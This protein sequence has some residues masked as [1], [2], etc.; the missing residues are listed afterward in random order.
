MLG[1]GA[2]L[3]AAVD[4]LCAALFLGSIETGENLTKTDERPFP[5]GHESAF[6]SSIDV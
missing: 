5:H 2:C 1:D 3:G 6:T 4:L